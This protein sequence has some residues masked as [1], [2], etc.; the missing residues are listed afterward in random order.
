MTKLLTVLLA[1]PVA[2]FAIPAAMAAGD[3]GA[4]ITRPAGYKPMVGDAALGEKLFS[5]AKLSPPTA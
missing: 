2:T 4:R 1:T 5:D 3:P